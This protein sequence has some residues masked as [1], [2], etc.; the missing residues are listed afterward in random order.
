MLCSAYVVLVL[1]LL[2]VINTGTNL[3]PKTRAGA[4]RQRTDPGSRPARRLVTDSESIE[5]EWEYRKRADW[6]QRGVPAGREDLVLVPVPG[7]H[8]ENPPCYLLNCTG[9]FT[10]SRWTMPSMSHGVHLT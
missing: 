10:T 9:I 3:T 6:Y 7:H 2:F 8:N 1:W 5:S 4:R